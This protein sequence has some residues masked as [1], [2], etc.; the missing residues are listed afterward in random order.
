VFAELVRPRP[1]P[2]VGVAATP[3]VSF[4]ASA[5]QLD[6]G[7]G[8]QMMFYASKRWSLKDRVIEIQM[9]AP[10]VPIG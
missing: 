10:N 9:N 8:D 7:T 3:S 4:Y 1:P 5:E 6:N 2:A